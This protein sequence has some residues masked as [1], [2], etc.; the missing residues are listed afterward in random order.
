MVPGHY[1]TYWIEHLAKITALDA[2]LDYF[3]MAKGYRIP[4][5]ACACV[6]PGKTPAT[7]TPLGRFN[8]RSF[9][10][11]LADGAT[12]PA[13]QELV[14]RGVAFEGGMGIADV[15]VSADGGESWMKAALGEDL[16]RYSFR[17]WTARL[18]LSPGKHSIKVRATNR[19]GQSQPLEPLW[20]PGGYMRNVV[21]TT[22]VT[23]A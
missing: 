18:A 22:T 11:S 10:T 20:N 12:V 6:D 2:P 4:N 14:L 19:A 9:L 21:E 13:D 17:E 3:W 8:V 7:T 23:A 15:V 16:G 1:G 5:N